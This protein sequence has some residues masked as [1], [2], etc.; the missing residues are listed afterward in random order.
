M[1]NIISAIGING[2]YANKD[3]LPWCKEVG[4][5]DMQFFRSY[6]LGKTVIM[7]YNTWLS[8]GKPL[9]NRLNVVITNKKHQ[10]T[11]GVIF[12]TLENAL[13]T[14]SDGI[15]IGGATLIKTI[16]TMFP[17]Y[18][19]EIIIN[20]FDTSFN[21]TTYFD[22]KSIPMLHKKIKCENYT[23]YRFFWPTAL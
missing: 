14:Y 17:K 7:G 23:Q 8:L 19:G 16:I 3:S 15:V 22:I 5:Y 13:V 1:V 10:L 2:E 9:P 21:A 4:K 18:I 20:Q 11:D 6:T 12:T